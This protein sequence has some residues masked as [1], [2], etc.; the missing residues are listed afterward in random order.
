MVSNTKA[1][2]YAISSSSSLDGSIAGYILGFSRCFKPG[3]SNQ[4]VLANDIDPLPA[5]LSAFLYSLKC[6]FK[7]ILTRNKEGRLDLVL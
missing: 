4:V 6:A 1:E 2:P 7:T 5:F 3:Q